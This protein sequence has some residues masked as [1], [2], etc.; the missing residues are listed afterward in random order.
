MQASVDFL[1]AV[2]VPTPPGYTVQWGPTGGAAG[3]TNPKAGEINVNADGIR[4]LS[5]NLEGDPTDFG[6]ILVVVLYHEYKHADGSFT[7]T[8]E[9]G[10]ACDHV[11][12]VHQVAAKN[13]ELI[14]LICQE[15]P[16]ADVKPICTFYSDV[17]DGY[18]NGSDG[19]GGASAAHAKYGCSD[20]YPGDI[21][22]CP[23][24]GPDG[25]C[26]GN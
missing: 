26:A 1:A 9:A 22:D 25:G 19:G 17:Q 10:R 6:G 21:P 7:N 11:Q 3:S 5:P 24:C 16:G 14:Q 13:C 12:Q 8:S 2:G 23:A 4:S 15:I 20:P 18:N